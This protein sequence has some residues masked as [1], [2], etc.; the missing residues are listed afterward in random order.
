MTHSCAYSGKNVERAAPIPKPRKPSREPIIVPLE[1][2][3]APVPDV[4]E[5]PIHYDFSL[6]PGPYVSAV[7]I[8]CD[9]EL[10][11]I[12]VQAQ[13]EMEIFIGM[14]SQ[15]KSEWRPLPGDDSGRPV[16]RYMARNAADI[17]REPSPNESIFMPLT[18]STWEQL[19]LAKRQELAGKFC[20]VL[21]PEDSDPKPLPLPWNFPTIRRLKGKDVGQVHS[22]SFQT[23][24]SPG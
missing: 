6:P 1:L 21:R 23:L 15:V 10:T 22:R 17:D 4:L 24:I 19:P 3:R 14:W 5:P 12:P 11:Y 16:P 18:V 2:W 8:T 9:A 7:S 13:H 20:L